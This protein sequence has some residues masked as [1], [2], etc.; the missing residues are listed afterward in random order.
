MLFSIKYLCEKLFSTH[1][2]TENKYG[3]QLRVK[4]ESRIQLSNIDN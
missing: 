3:N 1:V 4:S 2:F